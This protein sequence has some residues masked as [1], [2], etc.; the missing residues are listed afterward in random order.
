M[1]MPYLG[2][3]E[4]QQIAVSCKLWD[5]SITAQAIQSPGK[6]YMGGIQGQESKSCSLYTEFVPR[7]RY[8]SASVPLGCIRDNR[9]TLTPDST[10]PTLKNLHS[11]TN[12]FSSYS[13]RLMVIRAFFHE[14]F[15][16]I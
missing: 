14:Y 8:L 1:V 16:S 2:M 12:K 13:T 9:T 3:F 6:V 4:G 11:P 15:V 7:G 5:F 10:N